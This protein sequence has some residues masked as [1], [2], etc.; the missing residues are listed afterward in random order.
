MCLWPAVA[1]KG[2]YNGTGPLISL[3][4]PGRGSITPSQGGYSRPR[5][6]PASEGLRNSRSATAQ[7]CV[8][9]DLFY[10]LVG[11]LSRCGS[12]GFA[13]LGMNYFNTISNGLSGKGAVR[14]SAL[15]HREGRWGT[16]RSRKGAHLESGR[17]GS[18]RSF[19]TA[20]GCDPGQVVTVADAADVLLVCTRHSLSPGKL[21]AAYLQEPARSLR[22][23]SGCRS[24]CHFPQGRT[25]EPEKLRLPGAVFSQ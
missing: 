6:R 23:F 7:G 11:V 17:L 8:T 13:L 16:E 19:T 22:A 1:T 9:K 3:P 15:F 25:E 14:R 12:C 2:I 18:D 4:A 24:K 21:A 5:A 10:R 20:P